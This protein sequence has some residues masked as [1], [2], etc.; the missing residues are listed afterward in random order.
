MHKFS[1]AKTEE[2]QA[3]IILC[4]QNKQ[5]H[6]HLLRLPFASSTLLL[7]RRPPANPLPSSLSLFSLRSIAD[8]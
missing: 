8:L 6:W 7:T 5:Y 1:V 2:K 3:H 4:R